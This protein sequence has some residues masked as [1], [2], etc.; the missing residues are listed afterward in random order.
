MSGQYK[1]IATSGLQPAGLCTL[2]VFRPE[3][4]NWQT[5]LYSGSILPSQ[6]G[7]EEYGT[8]RRL[9][10]CSVWARLNQPRTGIQFVRTGLSI[11]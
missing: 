3:R 1:T 9:M 5:G 10:E 4:T 11:Q 6:N 7:R 8:S 2:T